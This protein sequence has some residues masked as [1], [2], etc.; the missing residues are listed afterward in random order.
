MA[1]IGREKRREKGVNGECATCVRC[2][3][4]LFSDFCAVLLIVFGDLI[5]WL[6]DS[7]ASFSRD[8]VGLL[9]AC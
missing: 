6:L 5:G 9:M 4:V 1:C 7:I 8:A 3:R 2:F